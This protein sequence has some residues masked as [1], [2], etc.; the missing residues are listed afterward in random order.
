M[1]L[2]VELWSYMRVRKKF[3]LLPILM[4]LFLL[5]GLLVP[6]PGLGAGAVHLHALLTCAPSLGSPPIITIARP[7]F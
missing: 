3:W 1:S 6:D 4:M 5:G 7:L 2:L